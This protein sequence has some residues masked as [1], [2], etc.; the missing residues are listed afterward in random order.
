MVRTAWLAVLTACVLS[1]GGACDIGKLTV[2]TTS[3]V[4]VRAAPSMEQEADWEM[5]SRAI[6]GT[7]KTIE[8]FHY[9]DPDN[10]R[11]KGLLAQGYCQY[12]AGFIEDDFELAD[13]AHD[14]DLMDYHA[15]RAT[16]AI[17]HRVASETVRPDP[18]SSARWFDGWKRETFG[19]GRDRAPRPPADP[20]PVARARTW[21]L[22]FGWRRHG[23]IDFE[24]APAAAA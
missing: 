20:P 14:V 9:V 1:L 13:Q 15:A 16:K 11:L 6:P 21:L 3:K 10:A 2:N 18:A 24:E 22:S 4:L 12:A 17:A 8:G 5:A 7:L 19:T 23:L